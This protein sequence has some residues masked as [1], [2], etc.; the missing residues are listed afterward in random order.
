M[1][2]VF[3]LVIIYFSGVIAVACPDFSGKYQKTDD[4]FTF[5]WIQQGCSSMSVTEFE[6]G[7]LQ[8]QIDGTFRQISTEP[9]QKAFLFLD[10]K[11]VYSYIRN[12][13]TSSMTTVYSKTV[14]GGLRG[15]VS[16][17]DLSSCRKSVNLYTLIQ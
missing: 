5:Q 1:Q 7:N 11:L 3:V 4:K 15:D 14:N 8:I 10:D 13:A 17:C 6:F 16:I 2:K 9:A 12:D